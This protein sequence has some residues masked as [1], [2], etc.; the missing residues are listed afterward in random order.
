MEGL[1][2]AKYLTIHA[3]T[4]D[5]SQVAFHIFDF[6]FKLDTFC[7]PSFHDIENDVIC[8]IT[9]SYLSLIHI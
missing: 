1:S 4:G 8:V 6:R 9:I 5:K 2:A 3:V 7:T